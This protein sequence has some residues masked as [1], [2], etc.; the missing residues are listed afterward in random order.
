[1]IDGWPRWQAQCLQHA[2]ASCADSR[3]HPGHADKAMAVLISKPAAMG[4]GAGNVSLRWC[5][6][7]LRLRH[8][9][10]LISE[11]GN[12]LSHDSPLLHAGMLMRRSTLS[13]SAQ[14]RCYSMHL[15]LSTPTPR[16]QLEPNSYAVIVTFAA[17]VLWLACKQI[18]W[19]SSLVFLDP[20]CG[21]T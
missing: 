1:M 16:P 15:L 2:M 6:R 21:L 10:H 12:R 4:S 18:A 20:C 3:C 9:P 14:L 8:M 11:E 5:L 7:A 19:A 13:C 17:I